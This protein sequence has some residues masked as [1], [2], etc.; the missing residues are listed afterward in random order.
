MRIQGSWKTE[1]AFGDADSISVRGYDVNELM[2]HL[3]FGEMVYLLI[4][5]ELPKRNEGRMMNALL[6]ATADHGIAPATV[7]SR[8]ITAA[9]S[10]IQASM[11]AGLLSFGDIQG[12]AMEAL[13]RELQASVSAGDGKGV[14]SV[15]GAFVDGFRGRQ[16][17]VPGFGHPLHPGGDPR[18]PALLR[19]ADQYSVSGPHVELVRA[20][21]EVLA[22]RLG[23]RLPLNI[24]GAFAAVGS[25]LGFDWRVV[26]GLILMSR[27]AGLAAHHLEELKTGKP[28]R[29][30]PPANFTLE[31]EEP[32]YE[33]PAKRSLPASHRR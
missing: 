32:Y 29:V 18:V 20:V 24:D 14:V 1:L 6:I 3:D 12:G 23:K 33:G 22:K 9:G 5:G 17:R 2:E 4:R 25:D 28:W 16:E 30:M 15:A 27:A 31:Y 7:V 8:Y 13:A 10:P 21:E 26:R 11:A 19:L